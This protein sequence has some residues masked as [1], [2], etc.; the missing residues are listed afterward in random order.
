MRKSKFTDTKHPYS[1]SFNKNKYLERLDSTEISDMF[2][3]FKKQ[4]MQDKQIKS[5]LNRETSISY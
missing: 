3:A 4:H 1:K 5:R 2:E